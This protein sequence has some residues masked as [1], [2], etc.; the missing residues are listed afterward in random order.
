MGLISL[1][2]V[3]RNNWVKIYLEV[4]EIL[5]F[6]CSVLLLVKQM[7]TI[8][9]C[10]IAKKKKKSKWLNAKIIV[11]QSWYNSIDSFFPVLYFAIFSKFSDDKVPRDLILTL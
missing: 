11:K 10:H 3:F 4:I 6:L 2:W 5:S 1:T 8:L 9:Q 7:A